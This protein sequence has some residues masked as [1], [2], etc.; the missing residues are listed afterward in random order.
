MKSKTI[1]LSI[2]P[3][4][5]EK[6]LSG[7]KHYEYRKKVPLDINQFLVYA[8]APIKKIVAIIEVDKVLNNT[9]KS[10]WNQTKK[11][12]GVSHDFFVNYFKNTSNAYA[13]KFRRIHK[14]IDPIE[15][16]L[17]DGIKCAP[18]S[19]VYVNMSFDDLCQKLNINPNF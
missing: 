15:I 19:Y 17:I 9:P 6:I 12:S 18:Q 14:L 1:I 16:T 13:I 3:Q 8:T 10:I 4:Y 2:N 11:Q 5:V 7:E